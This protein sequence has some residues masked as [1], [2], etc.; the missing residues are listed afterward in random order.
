[1]SLGCGNS[2][3][4]PKSASLRF[5]EWLRRS[6]P[7]GSQ[8]KKTTDLLKGL[9]LNTVCEEARCP[10]RLECYS[11]GTATF[12]VLG[13]ECTR[14]CGFCSIAFSKQPPPP[15]STEIERLV[16]SVQQ[17]QLRHVVITMVARDDLADGGAS[18]LVAIQRALRSQCPHA[19]VELLTSDFN[20]NLDA[21]D[22]V[23]AERPEVFNHNL[24]TVERLTPRVRHRATYRRSLAL[25]SQAKASFTGLL[26]SG[27]MV[28]LGEEREELEAALQDL[29]EVGCDIVTIGQY[30]QSDARK[31]RVKR[32]VP[33][34]EFEQLAEYGRRLGIRQM[35]CGPFVRSSYHAEIHL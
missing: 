12:L 7:S 3:A 32:F 24:E 31:L 35:F 4:A 16:A 28:G 25:L 22:A 13:R 11:Q 6:L 27:L 14:S 8:L 17:L 9:A 15:D 26:K 1:M 30:L 21:L 29:A 20:G 19:T 23:L 2:Q 34:E 18:H 5:P 33:P 10:N